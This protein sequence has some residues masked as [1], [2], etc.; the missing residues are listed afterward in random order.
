MTGGK[1]SS[2]APVIPLKDAAAARQEERRELASSAPI[3]RSRA[4]L[5][6]L[7]SHRVSHDSLDAEGDDDDDVDGSIRGFSA[8]SRG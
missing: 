2:L 1:Q 3:S 6:S 4:P 8:R 5:L 7:S